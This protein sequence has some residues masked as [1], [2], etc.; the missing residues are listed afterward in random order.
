M[1]SMQFALRIIC[2]RRITETVKDRVKVLANY[3]CL[4]NNLC[5]LPY[6]KDDE[7]DVLELDTKI[8]PP[9]YSKIKQ[10]VLAISGAESISQRCV[11]DEWEFAYFAS[12]DELHSSKDTAFVVCNIFRL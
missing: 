9:D 7:C 1:F 4:P 12:L 6:W 11:A 8:D 10:Y 2:N 3:L 5:F